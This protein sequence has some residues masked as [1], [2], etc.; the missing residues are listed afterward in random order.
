M[1]N[2]FTNPR[3]VAGAPAESPRAAPSRVVEAIRD[4]SERSGADFDY[5]LRTA[6][7]ESSLDPA[8][9]APTSTATGLFQFI[10]QTWLGTLKDAGPKFGLSG[11]SSEISE[12][13]P[14][15]YDVPDPAHKAEAIT[16]LPSR[17]NIAPELAS[18]AFDAFVAR[19]LPCI[20]ASGLRQVID[21]Y[22]QAEG[23]T[24]PKGEPGK[25]MD[26]S[27]QQRAGI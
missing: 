22:W 23:L 27:F 7:R 19:A 6:T 17:L 1:L 25:Y 11:Y 18:K 14:G 24:V 16:L 15:V 12:V 2:L 9:K 3:P 26:L 8:A 10:E 20:D 5:L 4:G 21:V 13:R